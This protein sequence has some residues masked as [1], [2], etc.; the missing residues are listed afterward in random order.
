MSTK[1]SLSKG[2]RVKVTVSPVSKLTAKGAQYE[3][4]SGDCTLED[5]KEDE[6]AKYIVAGESVGESIIK[7]SG[8]I[9]P[10]KEPGEGEEE[11]GTEG[12][13]TEQMKREERERR[14]KATP[15]EPGQ[16]GAEGEEEEEEPETAEELICVEVT[17]PNSGS[18]GVNVGTPEDVEDEEEE[19]GGEG[20][21]P[22]ADAGTPKK[23]RK[24]KDRGRKKP[25]K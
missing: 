7:V 12:P 3:V 9:H 8:K 13:E 5:D 20:T 18:L 19:E 14:P 6:T 2:Q 16:E 1:V 4:V 11:E 24:K 15:Y 23:R 22:G 25:K 21:E 17:D 10:K